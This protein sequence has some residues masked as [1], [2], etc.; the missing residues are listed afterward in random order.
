MRMRMRM[1][2]VDART[3]RVYTRRRMPLEMHCAGECHWECK[4][5]GDWECQGNVGLVGRLRASACACALSV[6]CDVLRCAGARA[7]WH[8]SQMLICVRA[9]TGTPCACTC[10]PCA[11]ASACAYDYVCNCECECAS[12]RIRVGACGLGY[13]GVRTCCESA[14]GRAAPVCTR[15]RMH[16]GYCAHA[17]AYAHAHARACPRMP[18]HARAR[19]LTWAR[20]FLHHA[21]GSGYA[22]ARVHAYTRS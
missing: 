19:A 4:C 9:C 18:A 22:C 3:L 16:T 14:C 1:L 7:S 6:V 17:H 5:A 10:T 8:A 13:A 12:V 20:V 15:S 2:V 11:C 21:D